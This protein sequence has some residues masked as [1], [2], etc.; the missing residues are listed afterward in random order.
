MK[1]KYIVVLMLIYMA[2]LSRLVPH[3]SNFA[4]ITGL[5]IFSG[6]Q[7]GKNWKAFLIPISAMLLSDLILEYTTGWG[8]YDG[9][10]LVYFSFM[11]ITVF[12]FY[13]LKQNTVANIA[14]VAI[15]S[16]I[17]FFVLTNF[18]VWFSGNIYPKTGAGLLACYTAGIPFFQ[19]SLLGDL[20]YSFGLFSGLGLFT[21]KFPTF[22]KA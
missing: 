21:K 20:V 7:F 2:A 5:A 12:S 16:S 9:M 8:F 18:G 3:P 11:L 10:W 13:T 6:F 14:L 19:N 15:S 17:L 1:N 22:S 4:P